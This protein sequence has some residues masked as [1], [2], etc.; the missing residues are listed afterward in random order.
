M[1][2]IEAIT[3]AYFPISYMFE[4]KE[5]YNFLFVSKEFYKLFHNNGFLQKIN[6]DGFKY[7]YMELINQLFSQLHYATKM[8]VSNF[9]NPHNLPEFTR[10][11]KLIDCPFDFFNPI[12][13]ITKLKYLDIQNEGYRNYS[14]INWVKIPNIETLIDSIVDSYEDFFINLNSYNYMDFKKKADLMSVSN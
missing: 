1:S 2:L 8:K 9:K 5:S 12:Y 4:T 7:D 3:R 6:L 14:N 11:V 13:T 10:S